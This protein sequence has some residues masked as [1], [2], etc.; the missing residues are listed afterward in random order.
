MHPHA[1]TDLAILQLYRKRELMDM[2]NCKLLL[3]KLLLSQ[4]QPWLMHL[5]L[6]T[7]VLIG[8]VDSMDKLLL[9]QLLLSPLFQMIRYTVNIILVI[10]MLMKKKYKDGWGFCTYI[11]SN[12]KI[13]CSHRY[14][15]CGSV[16]LF[17]L[18]FWHKTQLTI[19]YSWW[20]Q[21]TE[22]TWIQNCRKEK[23]VEE[24]TQ[25]RCL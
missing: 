15:W 1:R 16:W 13:R 7:L 19:I 10:F 25:W 5:K 24:K 2:N 9:S 14:A 18:K 22:V 4:L 3:D 23:S 11:M 21:L 8:K 17:G 6:D 12:L 20:C